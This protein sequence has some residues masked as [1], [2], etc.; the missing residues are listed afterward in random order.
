MRAHQP[1]K[2]PARIT[3]ETI[4]PQDTRPRVLHGSAHRVPAS[5]HTTRVHVISQ[6]R[7]LR[8]IEHQGT[9]SQNTCGSDDDTEPREMPPSQATL[10]SGNRTEAP[11]HTPLEPQ[12]IAEHSTRRAR[13][14]PDRAKVTGKRTQAPTPAHRAGTPPPGSHGEHGGA[15]RRTEGDL[16]PTGVYIHY[17]QARLKGKP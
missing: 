15:P 16:P 14:P 11:T 3:P 8:D 6:G 13:H 5:G 10:T 9:G 1:R 7:G 4:I 12:G 17:A 2:P